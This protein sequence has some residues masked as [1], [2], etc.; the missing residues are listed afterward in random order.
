MLWETK[1]EV[2]HGKRLKRDKG[3]A[4]Y[5]YSNKMQ[6]PIHSHSSEVPHFSAIITNFTWYIRLGAWTSPSKRYLHSGL[7]SSERLASVSARISEK[8]TLRKSSVSQRVA[9][10]N[11]HMESI[12]HSDDAGLQADQ[13]PT[14]AWL[15][16]PATKGL[17]LSHRR[18]A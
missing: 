4:V 5:F 2:I 15:M 18:F 9:S 3:S 14:Y 16:A 1:L 11:K 7:H 17:L 12:I 10:T 6:S 8:D 13:N